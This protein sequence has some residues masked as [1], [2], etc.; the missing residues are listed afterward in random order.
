M[1]STES[2][3]DFFTRIKEIVDGL[4]INGKV[5]E[6]VKVIEKI[7]NSLSLEFQTK[8]KDIESSQNL[9]T[10]KLDDLEREL[11]TYKMSLNQ[12]TTKTF[13]EASIGEST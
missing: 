1:K 5:L 7:L 2:I 13:D 8:K 3:I 9:N 6:E 12:Q 11:V 4:K 10:L